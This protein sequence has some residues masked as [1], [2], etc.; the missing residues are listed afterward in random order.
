MY[1]LSD[2]E[3]GS[4]RCSREQ[5][6]RQGVLKHSSSSSSS[7]PDANWSGSSCSSP[8]QRRGSTE[9]QPGLASRLGKQLAHS[10]GGL[11]A[12]AGHS[13]GGECPGSPVSTPK[14]LGRML[15][16]GMLKVS[17]VEVWSTAEWS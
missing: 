4:P 17:E 11:A 8:R 2:D 6:R 12:W 3:D 15:K 13:E 14:R 9:M 1:S 16:A 10:T 7:G 5:Q